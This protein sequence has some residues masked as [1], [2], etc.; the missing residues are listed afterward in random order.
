MDDEPR[1]WDGPP[2]YIDPGGGGEDGNG[3]LLL[4][5]L[6]LF[7]SLLAIRAVVG[8]VADLVANWS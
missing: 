2:N 4:V 8:L 6:G 1:C 3:P 7:F 5:M